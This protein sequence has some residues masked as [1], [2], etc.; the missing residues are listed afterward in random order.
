MIKRTIFQRIAS[1][2]DEPG[3]F[4][5]VLYGPH[6]VGKTT[7][8]GTGGIPFEEFFLMDLSKL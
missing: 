5:Q 8:V 7:L 1:R 4:I 2:L 3:M 6:Q